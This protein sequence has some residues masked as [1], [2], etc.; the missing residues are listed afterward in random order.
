[1]QRFLALGVF[2]NAGQDP[3]EDMMRKLVFAVMTAAPILATLPVAAHA[4]PF[5]P[6][7]YVERGDHYGPRYREDFRRRGWEHGQHHG[8]YRH[9]WWFKRHR[10]DHDYGM[11]RGPHRGW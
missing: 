5:G 3:M 6:R 8:W 9:P 11:Y 1:M 10:F 7:P 2:F 4:D